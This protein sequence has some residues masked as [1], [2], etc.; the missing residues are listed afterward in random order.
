MDIIRQAVLFVKGL[1][2]RGICAA[3]LPK[4]FFAV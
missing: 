1:V 2:C 3:V 4:N